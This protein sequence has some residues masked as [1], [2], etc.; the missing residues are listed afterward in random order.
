MG[1]LGRRHHLD[2]L[3][4][5]VVEA[6]GPNGLH[7]RDD[8]VG[9]VLGHNGIESVSVE[10]GD[11]FAFIRHLHGRS[12]RIGVHRDH[13][14]AVALQRD[15]HLFAQLA[16]AEQHHCL[17]HGRK[18]HEKGRHCAS[19]PFPQPP[20]CVKGSEASNSSNTAR[21]SGLEIN[22]SSKKQ[23]LARSMSRGLTEEV[24]RKTRDFR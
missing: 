7:F 12:A 2:A 19:N 15:D 23:A 11:D 22:R 21:E 16:G 20:C 17:L 18:L 1:R 24:N 8:D 13:P 3:L 6:L 5:V 4:L 14:L 9:A 10:H